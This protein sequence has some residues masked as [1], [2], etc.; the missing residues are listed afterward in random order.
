MS[1][2][3]SSR[4]SKSAA[5]H[6]Q[7]HSRQGRRAWSPR[8]PKAAGADRVAR[9]RLG[10]PRRG[11]RDARRPGR[12]RARIGQLPCPHRDGLAPGAP[13]IDHPGLAETLDHSSTG[14]LDTIEGG[15]WP[16]ACATSSRRCWRW[17]SRQHRPTTR[18]AARSRRCA[19]SRPGARAMSAT[20][21]A[22]STSSR[23]SSPGRPAPRPDTDPR[24]QDAGGA[25]A[26]ARGDDR[27]HRRQDGGNGS[28]DAVLFP[29]LEDSLADAEARR[30]RRARCWP[31]TPTPPR[32]AIAEQ[33]DLIRTTTGKERERPRPRCAPPMSRRSARSPSCSAA[34]QNAS[35]RRP[36]K[37]AAW[38]KPDP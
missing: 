16:T 6:R 21:P 33:F 35:R 18:S 23:P 5:P 4:R 12:R 28:P 17:P 34:P 36:R 27:H 19:T 31:T 32:K 30:D 8:W 20:S 26:C 13:D 38:R 9:D 29:L 24:R 37:C 10:Y 14:S 22:A 11:D 2:R 3:A 1:A 25:P 7:H 15:A